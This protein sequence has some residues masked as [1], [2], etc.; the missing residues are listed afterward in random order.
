MKIYLLTLTFAL[1]ISVFSSESE[2][3]NTNAQTMLLVHKTPTCGCCKKWIKHLEMSGLNTTT[4]NHG[5][6]EEI[7]ATYN[8][9]PEYRSCHTTVSSNGFIFEGH[10]PSKYIKQFLS[11]T[12]ENAIGLSVPGMPLGSPGME[13]EDRFMPYEVLILYKDGS[14]NVYAAVENK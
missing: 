12:H 7:K 6:L 2:M 4:K 5:S 14:S 13:Y 11:E 9:K 3:P 8:I 10:I 1:T